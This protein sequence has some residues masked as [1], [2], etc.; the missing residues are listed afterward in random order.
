MYK[1]IDYITEGKMIRNSDGVS[2]LSFTDA[3]DLVLLYFLAL[4]IMRHYPSR[5]FVKTYSDEVLKWQN[6]DHFRSSG[7]D[8]Y[9]LLNI[10]DGDEA[11]VDKLQN[12]RNAKILR[13]R[14]TF[15]TLTAKRLL[16][17]FSNASPSFSDANDL[18]KID[19]SLQNS[20]YSN[21]RRRVANYAK[22][23]NQEK[24]KAVTELE[25][26]LKAR[27]RNSDIVDYYVMFVQDF[28]LESRTTKDT[29][30]RISVPDVVEPETKDIQMLRMLG[31]PNKDLPFAYKVLSLTSRGLGI[32]PRFAQAYAPIMRIID[33]I[34]KAG[35]GYVNLLKQV[36]NR[37]RSVKK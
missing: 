27:G 20:R 13:Q 10:V 21:L 8:F 29:E 17:S 1:F 11:I 30:P 23:T 7:N 36:H 6:W 24:K 16:R 25:N 3:S 5:R 26:A 33:D 37:A 35:P 22:L 32:P 9:N 31:V 2:R 28:D 34:V 12:P 4:H 14:S 19:N 18:V 15:P